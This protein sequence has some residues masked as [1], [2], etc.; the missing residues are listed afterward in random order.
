MQAFYATVDYSF[1]LKGRQDMR[2]QKKTRSGA[3]LRVAVFTVFIFSLTVLIN[4]SGGGGGNDNHT[5]SS[6][7]DSMIWDQDNWQ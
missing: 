5:G 4:C 3:L 6:Q 2:T 1:T 7:W